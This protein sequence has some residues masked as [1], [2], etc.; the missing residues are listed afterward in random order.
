MTR[1]IRRAP[2]EAPAEPR[3]HP[4]RARRRRR[5]LAARDR[6]LRDREHAA[7]GR[8]ARRSHARP[9]LHDRRAPRCDGPHRAPRPAHRAPRTAR[10]LKRLQRI[11]ELPPPISAPSSS[12]S[13]PCSTPTA[14]ARHAHARNAR[15]ADRTSVRWQLKKKPGRISS[16]GLL[17]RAVSISVARFR[18]CSVQSATGRCRR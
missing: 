18:W 2:G 7:P 15:R 14:A 10:S 1:W 6:L 17:P 13:K 8:A 4:D 3:A 11:E 9:P 12:S 16:V 5:G